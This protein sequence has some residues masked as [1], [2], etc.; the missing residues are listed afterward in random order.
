MTNNQYTYNQPAD[1]EDGDEWSRYWIRNELNRQQN[2]EKLHFYVH[3]LVY[4]DFFL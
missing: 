4:M 2:E 3:I 1:A